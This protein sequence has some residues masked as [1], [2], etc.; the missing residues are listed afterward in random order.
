MPRAWF[1]DAWSLLRWFRNSKE[2]TVP[3]NLPK[4]GHLAHV[5][6]MHTVLHRMRPPL[7]CK[8]RLTSIEC[9]GFPADPRHN[10]GHT[11]SPLFT[12]TCWHAYRHTQHSEYPHSHGIHVPLGPALLGSGPPPRLLENLPIAP[13]ISPKPNFWPCC[14]GN[15]TWFPGLGLHHGLPMVLC[16]CGVGVCPW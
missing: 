11:P 14:S 9:L 15:L 7:Q 8:P 3:A 6:R 16:V 1:N 10:S 4:R 2:V 12:D 5:V 13:T